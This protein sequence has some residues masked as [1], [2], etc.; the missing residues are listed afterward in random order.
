MYSKFLELCSRRFLDGYRVQCS[1]SKFDN[2]IVAMSSGVDSSVCAALYAGFPNVSGIYMQNWSEQSEPIS[3]NANNEPCYEKDWKDVKRVASHLNIP[4]ERANF[5]K[6]YWLDV[7]E[8]ML[9]EYERGYTPNPDIG[10]NKFLKFGKLRTYLNQKYGCGNYWLVTG[11]YARVQIHKTTEENHLLRGYYSAK[12][13]SYY[14]SQVDPAVL[15]SLLMPIGHLTKPEVR[16]WAD[17]AGLP[18]ASKP[19]SQ[20]ICF[21]NNSQ[22]RFHDFLNEYLPIKR[23]HFISVDV[24]TGE[25]RV[26]GEHKGLWTYTIG[27][28]VGL[29]MPQGDPR[30]K[31]AWYVSEKHMDTNDIVIVRGT[32]N[33][34]LYKQNVTVSNFTTIGVIKTIIHDMKDAIAK[35][36]LYMQFR[37]LQD[38]IRVVSCKWEDRHKLTLLLSAKQR[39]MAP[40]QYCCI[41]LQDRVLGSGI[42]SSTF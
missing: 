30:Y 29:P 23:G 33:E 42:I 8:P 16:Q 41:Y 26:W 28:K 6:D 38:P 3:S 37:S 20:G 14:L 21:V 1:P 25:K 31:G 35:G 11:H 12:D 5:E 15:D 34:S 36:L 18:T 2:I 13:Q 19:D 27:Q 39:A 10:C 24:L 7:F 40:G 22:K 9:Q 17:K 32:D 4:V